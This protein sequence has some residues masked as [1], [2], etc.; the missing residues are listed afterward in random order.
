M[1]GTLPRDLERRWGAGEDGVYL[2]RLVNSRNSKLEDAL[3]RRYGTEGGLTRGID[4][5]VDAF[6]ALMDELSAGLDGEE[7]VEK[8]LGSDAGKVFMLLAKVSGQLP[9]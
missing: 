2:R 5:Y 4:A 7:Q 8:A 1:E 3:S 6:A 9:A